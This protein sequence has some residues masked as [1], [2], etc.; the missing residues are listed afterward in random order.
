MSLA[1]VM[2]IQKITVIDLAKKLDVSE[3]TIYNWIENKIP[4]KRIGEL[5]S[6]FHVDEQALTKDLSYIEELEQAVKY[7]Q[8]NYAI[9]QRLLDKEQE[10]DKVMAQ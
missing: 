6:I 10:L 2:E 9:L 7:H 1:Q 5:S 4:K 3:R 8:L